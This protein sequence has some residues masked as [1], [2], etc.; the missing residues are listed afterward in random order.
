MATAGSGMDFELLPVVGG[1]GKR[2]VFVDI[3]VRSPL[4]LLPR[5]PATPSSG[6]GH[7]KLTDR[8]LAHV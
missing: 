5:I 7:A 2:W 6:W 4:L 8:Q 1:F 3:G